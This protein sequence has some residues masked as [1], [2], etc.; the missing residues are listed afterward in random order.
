MKPGSFAGLVIFAVLFSIFVA[1]PEH[2]PEDSRYSLVLSQAILER[3]SFV[4]DGYFVPLRERYPT[5]FE[6]INGHRYYYFPPGSSVLSIP[7]VAAMNALGVSTVSPDRHYNYEGEKLIQ[8]LL[9]AALMAGLGALFATI[10][11]SILPPPWWL[12]ALAGIELG[13]PVMST[14]S[15]TLWSD[16]WGIF[17]TGWVVWLLL[18][19]DLDEGH[20]HPVWLATILVW[21]YIVRPTNS[22]VILGATLYILIYHRRIWWTYCAT[23]AAWLAGFVAYSWY[24]FGKL[25]PSYFQPSRLAPASPMIGLLANTI[26]P[27]R[28]VV[29]LVPTLMLAAYLVLRYRSYLPHRRLVVLAAATAALHVAVVSSY[30]QW[31]AGWSYGPRF[32]TAMVPWFGFLA[33]A[34]LKG[35]LN[36][37]AKGRS[38]MLARRLENAVGVALLAASIALN[39]YGAISPAAYRWNEGLPDIDARPMRVFDWKHP[40]FLA[41]LW[42]KT[43]TET[44]PALPDRVPK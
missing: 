15:R 4:L 7:I 19:L 23:V 18:K 22:I 10:A 39:G 36:A 20:D 35:M 12:F 30:W 43:I 44:L 25:L 24:N 8:A 40:Q 28:G 29:V 13:S 16:S 21:S 27:S 32:M 31:W 37:R 1:C 2:H 6:T 42:P 34:G 33:I 38:S 5:H 41:G 9:A 17:L 14:A 11:W 26:S 3:E